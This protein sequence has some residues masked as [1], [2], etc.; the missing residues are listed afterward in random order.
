MTK[1]EGHYKHSWVI[2]HELCFRK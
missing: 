2:C 1:V